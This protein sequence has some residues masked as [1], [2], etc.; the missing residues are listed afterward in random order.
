MFCLGV[1]GGGTSTRATVIDETGA[2]RGASSGLTANPYASSEEEA[3]RNLE[4]VVRD[5][6]RDAGTNAVERGVFALAGVSTRRDETASLER[7][8]ASPIAAM[9]RSIT[10]TNDT[11]AALWSTRCPL[12]AI[13]LVAGTG[14]HC[15]GVTAGGSV[16]RAQGLEY[17]L[18]DEG[19]AF[20]IG[21][22]AARAVIRSVNGTAP[23]TVLRKSVADALD[24]PTLSD[25]FH[26][27]HAA[28][29]IKSTFAALA[30]H[31][32]RAAMAGDRVARAVLRQASRSLF[33]AVAGVAAR[34][35]IRNAPFTLVLI[36]GVLQQSAIVRETLIARIVRR[37][38][39]AT[40]SLV[41][42]DGSLGAA[43]LA[44][45]DVRLDV[46][47]CY[48]RPIAS[49]DPGPSSEPGAR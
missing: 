4:S 6:L 3:I 19:S 39:Q 14:S 48:E 41:E 44:R 12:P 42:T 49:D 35:E 20:A 31:V 13:V 33:D 37:Y 27:V 15:L 26:R 28:A 17:V 29:S 7:V 8:L 36:G 21:L 5:A 40:V 10:V 34:L 30:P 23:G 24:A 1:D 18:S 45:D 22:S 25:I 9:V 38:P 2:V 16:E 32:D 47:S 11:L 46:W 43:L